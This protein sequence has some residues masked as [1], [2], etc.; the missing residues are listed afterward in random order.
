MCALCGG[1]D[2]LDELSKKKK[3]NHSNR[4]FIMKLMKLLLQAIS[5]SS[6]FP[7]WSPCTEAATPPPGHFYLVNFISDSNMV[8]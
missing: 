5:Y 3:K 1:L 6:F 4:R 7:K 2:N 8:K